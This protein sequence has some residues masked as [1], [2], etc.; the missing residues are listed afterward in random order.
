MGGK[1]G[2]VALRQEDRW[3]SESIVDFTPLTNTLVL[4]SLQSDHSSVCI[5]EYLEVTILIQG[6]ESTSRRRRLVR[7]RLDQ[8]RQKLALHLRAKGRLA[9]N[10][11]EQPPRC[12]TSQLTNFQSVSSHLVQRRKSTYGY[13]DIALSYY[14]RALWRYRILPILLVSHPP[15]CSISLPAD[16]TTYQS[17]LHC[18]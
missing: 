18:V 16:S 15:D 11:K 4:A 17:Y 14:S 3:R 2:R 12:C 9:F 13:T 1:G 7:F 6:R 10:A 8:H 5:A